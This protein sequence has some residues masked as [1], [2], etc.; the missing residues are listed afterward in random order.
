M[1]FFGPMKP[2][3]KYYF[4]EAVVWKSSPDNL[5]F[6][7]SRHIVDSLADDVPGECAVCK[8]LFEETI[9]PSSEDDKTRYGKTKKLIRKKIF[10][11]I[12]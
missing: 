4:T 9:P 8:V 7:R 6:R 1:L 3:G 2:L 11:N 5:E 10:F 12:N